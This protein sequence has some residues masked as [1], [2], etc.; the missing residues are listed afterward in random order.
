MSVRIYPYTTLNGDVTLRIGGVTLDGNSVVPDFI[1][2]ERRTIG[3][4]AIGNSRWETLSFTVCV[5]GP[6]SELSIT[7]G[8]WTNVDAVVVANCPRSN[9]RVSVP[10]RAE[11]GSPARWTGTAELD[12]D[13]FFGGIG[14]RALVTATVDRVDRRLIGSAD[15]WQ[16][17]LDDLPRPPVGQA[18]TI[19]WERFGSP[20]D[21][22]TYLAQYQSEPYFLK[23]DSTDP[24]LFLN[25]DFEGLHGLL[26]D[27]RRRPPAERAL[28]DHTRG[29][30]AAQAWLVLFIDSLSHASVSDGDL[31]WPE[32]EWRGNVLRALLESMYGGADDETLRRAWEDWQDKDSLA[33]VL[34]RALPA[35]SAQGRLA[36]LLRGAIRTLPNVETVSETEDE[37][38][39]R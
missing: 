19:V 36:R 8:P 31:T 12:R 4:S 2:Q 1:D 3:I 25:N 34:E 18:M 5:D 6:V 37:G 33:N 17:A 29:A 30:I 24:V 27:R 9:T 39:D 35:A 21:N 26:A 32:E 22:R 10:L 38:A 16:I 20:S 15:P 11:T 7:D 13:E 28:H 14:V 23:I